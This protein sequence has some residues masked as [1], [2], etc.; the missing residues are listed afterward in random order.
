M[1]VDTTPTSH[2]RIDPIEHIQSY[3]ESLHTLFELGEVGDLESDEV[4]E[5][6][7]KRSADYIEDVDSLVRLVLDP[8]FMGTEDDEYIQ[9]VPEDVFW[10][11]VHAIL[12]L[13]ALAP[14]EAAEPL[15]GLFEKEDEGLVE[16]LPSV[17][18]AI[19][20]PA[21]PALW[22]YIKDTS[23]AFSNRGFCLRFVGSIG[24]ADS[25]AKAQVTEELMEHL[26]RDERA[27]SADEEFINASAVSALCDL[28]A[29]EV[30]AN[31]EQEEP[32]ENPVYTLI[33]DAFEQDIL[34]DHIISLQDVN[35]EFGLREGWTEQERQDNANTPRMSLECTACG[36]MRYYPVSVVYFDPY[37]E[38]TKSDD[39]FFHGPL[40]IPDTI[41]CS[42]CGVQ[43]SYKLSPHGQQ[44]I[45]IAGMMEMAASKQPK[46]QGESHP[47]IKFVQFE[48]L[49]FGA[50]PRAAKQKYEKILEGH[51]QDPSVY[52]EYARL[53]MLFRQSELAE[54]QLTSALN[55]ENEHPEALYYLARLA[56]KAD[57]LD[58]ALL[59]WERARSAALHD[60]KLS[61]K[62][63]KTIVDEA[64]T[65]LTMANKGR[66]PKRFEGTKIKANDRCPCGS[67]K[68]FK[69]CCM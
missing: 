33:A 1:T 53:L 59:F 63:K 40:F 68:K 18:G 54:K 19:G 45:A 31:K 43:D 49:G 47:F 48:Q 2:E 3:P 57:R 35:I 65:R 61:R 24:E 64:S 60:R 5:E 55:L 58:E 7:A 44:T 27:E 26:R 21:L 22:S 42:K 37:L 29:A 50:H 16:L 8:V 11:P 14:V 62:L 25:S 69:K 23:K 32:S 56:E 6:Y 36:R 10:A 52:I 46:G 13:E 9:H 20:V 66:A 12:L 39:D 28:H 51:P 38:E 15:L 4:T 17:Y 41:V 30:A 34:G 67:G